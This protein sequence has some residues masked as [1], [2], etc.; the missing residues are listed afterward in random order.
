MPG[1]AYH[2]KVGLGTTEPA[3][4][5]YGS[6]P[7]RPADELREF[8]KV[9]GTECDRYEEDYL[10]RRKQ[11]KWELFQCPSGVELS[12]FVDKGGQ[13]GGGENVPVVCLHGVVDGAFLFM[14]RAPVST[15]TASSAR[16]TGR[17]AI[18]FV[19]M[20]ARRRAARMGEG[21]MM[22]SRWRET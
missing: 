4:L 21:A 6:A 17:R 19:V 22:T 8:P 5:D 10:E 20:R 1:S 12:F 15:F 14:Q 13:N 2:R 11:L 16:G 9:W 7:G 3:A 18:R